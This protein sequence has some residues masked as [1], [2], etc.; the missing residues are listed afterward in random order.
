MA[1]TKYL[2]API[3]SKKM[4][5]STPYIMISEATERYAFYAFDA[6]LALFL[7]NNLIDWHGNPAKLTE[8]QAMEWKHYFKAAAYF[9][10]FIGSIISDVFL[11]K[12][13][14]IIAFSIVYFLGFLTITV[15]QSYIG[16]MIGLG[17]IALGSG[18]IKPCLSA[19]LGDQFGQSNQHLITRAFNMFYWAV[20]IGAFFS[21]AISPWIYDR[22]N[23]VRIALGIPGIFMMLTIITYWLGRKSMVHIPP[24]GSDFFEDLFSKEGLLI[25]IRLAFFLFIFVAVFWS[26]FD[27]T[28]S[29]WVYQAEEMN[30]TFL[31]WNI[32]DQ[33]FFGSLL[34]KLWGLNHIE[35]KI[36]PA[37]MQAVNC[38]LVLITIPFFTYIVYPLI[39]KF[40]RLTPLRKIGIG[41]FVAIPSFAIPALLEKWIQ[42]GTDPTIWWQVLAYWFITAGEV[43]I[44]IPA[45]EFAYTQA[46]KSMKS[47][48][49]SLYLVSISLGNLFISLVNKFIQNPDG[50]VKLE[51]PSYY[52]FFTILLLVTGIIFCFVVQFYKGKTYIQDEAPADAE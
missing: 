46:P 44:S 19:N 45:L 47:F 48:I 20:N 15:D 38:I 42:A 50:T 16:T 39:N 34:S 24:K 9:T 7:V 1:K 52:W 6:I 32:S 37:Q 31:K 49:S 28:T 5:P 29:K 18:I 27:Q 43:L 12:Y 4:P 40:F 41:F 2:T 22:Y 23:N 13:R 21:M 33:T 10:P 51:G 25:L 8:E 30:L 11:G 26:L 36:L 3:P 17:L 35:W 14:T